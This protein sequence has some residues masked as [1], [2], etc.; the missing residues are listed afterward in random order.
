MFLIKAGNGNRKSRVV[1]AFLNSVVWQD[2]LRKW[3]LGK[4]LKEVSFEDIFNESIKGRGNGQSKDTMLG[5]YLV[6]SSN[7]KIIVD[8]AM[9]A[10][11]KKWVLGSER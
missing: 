3:H 9:W 7:K 4:N 11:E 1:V 2:V 10:R 6:S 5:G 8:E